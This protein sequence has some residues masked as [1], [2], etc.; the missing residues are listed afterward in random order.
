MVQAGRDEA[1]LFKQLL[2]D[3]GQ[4]RWGMVEPQSQHD[5][6]TIQGKDYTGIAP[7]GYDEAWEVKGARLSADPSQQD[8]STFA[9]DL[10]FISGPNVGSKGRPDGSRTRT[11]NAMLAADYSAF[12]E[13]VRCAVRA[14]I[15]KSDELGC[16]I[17]LMAGASTGLYAGRF[18][19][20][21]NR[22]FVGLVDEALAELNLRHVQL[23]Y[24]VT[25]PGKDPQS[26][27]ASES[28]DMHSS[29]KQ[30][31]SR[32]VVP[33]GVIDDGKGAAV[34]TASCADAGEAGSAA[35]AVTDVDVAALASASE[36]VDNTAPPLG[37]VRD[38][39]D[40]DGIL[41]KKILS[42]FDA[43]A[44]PVCCTGAVPS[45]FVSR[46]C[47][48]LTYAKLYGARKATVKSKHLCLPGHRVEPG[49]ITAK[50]APASSSQPR[51]LG[52]HTQWLLG[53]SRSK[54]QLP[55]PHPEQGDDHAARLAWFSDCLVQIEG[56]QSPPKRLAFAKDAFETNDWAPYRHAIES[57][58]ARNPDMCVA[59]VSTNS[60]VLARR[61]GA[62]VE[63]VAATQEAIAKASEA[64]DDLERMQLTALANVIQEAFTTEKE[65]PADPEV[66]SKQPPL[67]TSASSATTSDTLNATA[68]ASASE[69]ATPATPTDRS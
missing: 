37:G 29:L 69:A 17:V 53:R 4:P 32:V 43:I 56:L 55:T 14:S 65:R 51:V 59:V 11:Y 50:E 42:A 67:P 34:R 40:T 3:S 47:G 22:D 1:D 12:C 58:S 64:S 8:S 68:A 7:S 6:R 10:V 9:T 54:G 66:E 33:T 62:A 63:V 41:G 5:C 46:L 2:D 20:R 45:S 27:D 18:K 16:Q 15:R 31:V 61:G 52:L 35:P 48:T 60:S 30:S 44:V 23:V 28:A 49:Q 13:G 19:G 26:V 36:A 57:F 21:I 38:I 25:L 39:S 24:Y